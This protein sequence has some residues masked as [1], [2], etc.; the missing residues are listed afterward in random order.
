MKDK[1]G[2]GRNRQGDPSR[3]DAGLIPV[4]GEGVRGKEEYGRK[5]LRPQYTLEKVLARLRG[6]P[7]HSYPL[8][9]SSEIKDLP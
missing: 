6:V 9:E 1:G 8:E 2:G 5:S 3:C 4:K 7:G